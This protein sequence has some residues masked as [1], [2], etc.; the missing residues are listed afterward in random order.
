VRNV[1]ACARAHDESIQE[2]ISLLPSRPWG[3]RARAR[4]Y[5]SV[6]RDCGLGLRVSQHV[7]L[8]F[9][10]NISVGPNVFMN[11]G[12]FMA[13]RALI[14][15]GEDTL[16]GPYTIV[17]S[18]DHRYRDAGQLIRRQGHEPQPIV[19][20][21][22]VWIGAHCTILKGVVLGTGCVVAAG[23]VV[24]SDVDPYT[25]VAGTPARPIGARSEIEGAV[26]SG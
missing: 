21:D 19:I 23:A 15:I 26:A 17:N 3:A 24:T 2:L 14:T 18:G 6:L 1:W 8:K 5:R 11:R 9:P 12:V 7:I 4:Y 16:I 13:A 22:D 25:V 20:G 10:Q